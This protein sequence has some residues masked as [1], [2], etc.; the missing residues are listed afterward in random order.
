MKEMYLKFQSK[1]PNQTI[2]IK[3]KVGQGLAKRTHQLKIRILR[4]ERR[5]EGHEEAERLLKLWKNDNYVF[6]SRKMDVKC[7]WTCTNEWWMAKKLWIVAKIYTNYEASIWQRDV[8]ISFPDDTQKLVSWAC[9]QQCMWRQSSFS[10]IWQYWRG[11][12]RI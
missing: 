10:K 6:D 12:F 9:L 11:E 1:C 5:R 4:L 8:Y 7:L 2:R 3:P